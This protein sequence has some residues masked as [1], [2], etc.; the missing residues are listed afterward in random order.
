[1]LVRVDFE[2]NEYK[3]IEQSTDS[4][5]LN[6][7]FISL[8]SNGLETLREISPDVAIACEQQVEKFVVDGYVNEWIHSNTKVSKLYRVTLSCAM[9]CKEFTATLKVLNTKSG[10][11]SAERVVFRSKPDELLFHSKL[12]KVRVDQGRAVLIDKFERPV[13]FIELPPGVRGH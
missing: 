9:T 6:N 4:V 5:L 13:G 11:I 2:I 3:K 8:L 12:G 10:S 7:Y 1:M